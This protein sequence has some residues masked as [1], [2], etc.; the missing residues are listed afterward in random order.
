MILRNFMMSKAIWSYIIS[1]FTN[2]FPLDSCTFLSSCFPWEGKWFTGSGSH[3]LKLF[4]Q[5]CGLIISFF[6]DFP[7][8]DLGMKLKG[9]K[10]HTRGRQETQK[11]R[12]T[13]EE[14]R[15]MTNGK[16]LCS[17]NS[18]GQRK[19]KKYFVFTHAQE[20]LGF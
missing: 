10:Q 13:T 20:M 4:P 18:C 16:L 2:M 6:H 3:G 17:V 12:K 11:T 7:M 8:L 1:S 9:E 15:K 19:K 14:S 5:F